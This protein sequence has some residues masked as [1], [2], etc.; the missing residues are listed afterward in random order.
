VSKLVRNVPMLN[1][2]EVSPFLLM[3]FS[4]VQHPGA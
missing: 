2:L 4:V 1:S 3:S